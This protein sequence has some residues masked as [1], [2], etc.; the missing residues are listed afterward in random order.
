MVRWSVG[1][2]TATLV[3]RTAELVLDADTRLSLSMPD[4]ALSVLDA[5][6]ADRGERGPQVVAGEADA[7]GKQRKNARDVSVKSKNQK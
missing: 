5:W 6:G 3:D 4:V 7:R 2:D 1:A